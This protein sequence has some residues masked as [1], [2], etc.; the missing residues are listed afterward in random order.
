MYG[1]VDTGGPLEGEVVQKH[2]LMW[3]MLIFD[4]FPIRYILSDNIIMDLTFNHWKGCGPVK[5]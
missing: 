4:K 1:T 2:D 3:S 5:S